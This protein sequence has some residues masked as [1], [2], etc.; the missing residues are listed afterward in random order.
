MGKTR[1]GY[2]RKRKFYGNRHATGQEKRTNLEI[3]PPCATPSSSDIA[4]DATARP[5]EG[6]SASARKIGTPEPQRA[7]NAE[8]EVKGFRFID[9]AILSTIFKMLPCKQ[10]QQFNLELIENVSKR[11]GCASNLELHCKSCNWK[12]E[13]YTSAKINYFFEVNRRLVYAMRLVGC[14]ASSA[15]RFCGLMNMPPIPRSAPML[16]ITKLF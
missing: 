3:P 7:V 1:S 8:V 5:P 15:E 14:G 9:L 13:F 4:N 12:E 11:K 10:C 6:P 2:S 16:R